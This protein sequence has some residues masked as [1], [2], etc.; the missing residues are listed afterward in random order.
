MSAR[1]D[2]PSLADGVIKG[3]VDRLR[4]N[5]FYLGDRN[6]S[7]RLS[8]F[9]TQGTNVLIDESVKPSP[10]TTIDRLPL[11]V[12]SAI[13]VLT[14]EDFWLSSDGYWEESVVDAPSIA[15]VTLSCTGAAPSLG[16]LDKHFVN[17]VRNLNTLIG[18]MRTTCCKRHVQSLSAITLL[19]KVKFNHILFEVRVC[20]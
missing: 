20:R 12:M 8:W 16:Y 6:T 5:T 2:L 3:I 11:A 15:D 19:P 18:R 1:P 10:S 17:V 4:S 7:D 14:G 13:V 9:E